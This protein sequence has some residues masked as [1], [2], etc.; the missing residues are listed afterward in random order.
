MMMKTAAELYVLYYAGDTKKKIYLFN[1]L[2]KPKRIIGAY[3]KYG[4][5]KKITFS[6]GTSIKASN[7]HLMMM[8]ASSSNNEFKPFDEFVIGDTVIGK[9]Y[10]EMK[11]VV[12][13]EDVPE[14][15]WYDFS[16]DDP[17]ESYLIDGVI[18]HNSGKSAI[19]YYLALWNLKKNSGRTLLIVP[20]TNLVEQMAS[21]FQ[22]YAGK[23]FLPDDLIHKIYSGCSTNKDTSDQSLSPIVISTWQ[24]LLSMLKKNSNREFFASF[25]LILQDEVHLGNAKEVAAV[26]S[27]C[28]NAS[29]RIGLTGTLKDSKIDLLQLK[30]L[31]GPVF[32]TT[33]TKQLQDRKEL[34]PLDINVLILNYPEKIRKEFNYKSKPDYQKEIDYITSLENR[35]HFITNLALST[36]GNTLVLFNLVEKHGI[37]LY[38]M[39]EEKTNNKDRKTFFISGSTDVDSREKMRT[40][41]EKENNAIICGSVGTMSTGVNMKN[42][43]NIIFAFSTKSQVRVLQSIGRGLRIAENNQETKLFDVVDNLSWKSKKNYCLKH[44]LIRLEFYQEEQF[45]YKIKDIPF[46][47]DSI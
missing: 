29:Y 14:Q 46:S 42:I 35:N 36:S 1:P 30:G 21:D 20:S 7:N 39:I 15:E 5:G 41:V 10:V 22:D 44:A 34:A 4:K 23:S 40:I 47:P 16:I 37:P 32:T 31:F 24:S 26:S 43:H 2:G 33:T 3:K 38:K 13:I 19:I 25:N 27:A 45:L 12:D 9:N 6:D 11:H 18:H 17:S 28:T 8:M